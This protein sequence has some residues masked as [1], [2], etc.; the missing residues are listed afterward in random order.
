MRKQVDHNC[1]WAAE[2]VRTE[3]YK[4]EDGSRLVARDTTSTEAVGMGFSATA[5]AAPN[6]VRKT[7]VRKGKKPSTATKTRN[8]TN[9]HCFRCGKKGHRNLDFPKNKDSWTAE[10]KA[11]GKEAQAVF[12]KAR[13]DTLA[14]SVD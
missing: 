1:E 4:V 11:K 3:V 5:K 14:R 9:L 13:A 6:K 12:N 7:N 2:M 10:E 8:S